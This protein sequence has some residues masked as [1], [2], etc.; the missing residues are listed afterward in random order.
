M[1]PSLILMLVL[2]DMSYFTSLPFLA[3]WFVNQIKEPT[4]LPITTFYCYK[5]TDIL[6][7]FDTN[8]GGKVDES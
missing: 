5:S 3:L 6:L 2:C 7:P 1:I 8:I 4:V